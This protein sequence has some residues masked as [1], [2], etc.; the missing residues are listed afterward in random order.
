MITWNWDAISAGAA[1]LSTLALVGSLY[2]LRRQLLAQSWAELYGLM[3]GEDTR[4]ARKRLYELSETPVPIKDWA[5]ETIK[6][7]ELICQRYNYFARMVSLHFLPKR[8]ALQDWA[9]QFDRLWRVSKP[10]VDKWRKRPGE[11]RLWEDFQS[12][13][14][15]SSKWLADNGP[16]AVLPVE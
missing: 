16:V 1:A 2:L 5:P 14:E 10:Y 11:G 13:A 4:M 3:Q 8:R 15:K 6:A 12:F 9:W 7:V